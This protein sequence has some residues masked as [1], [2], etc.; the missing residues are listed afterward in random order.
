M[1]TVTKK[2]G[3]LSEV[4]ELHHRRVYYI[5]LLGIALMLSFSFLDYILV[6]SYFYEFLV[7]R[8][9]VCGCALL[10]VAANYYDRQKRWSLAIGFLGYVFAG[11]VIL[12]M[13]HKMGGTQSPYY[14]GLIV[15]MTIYTTLTPLTLTQALVSGFLLIAGYLL[16]VISG[17]LLIT[18]Q[19]LWVFSNFFFMFCFVCIAATQSATETNAR[20]F[21][22]NLRQQEQRAAL[23]LQKQ[24]GN[25]EKEVSQR[26]TQIK[27]SE[28]KYQLLFNSLADDVVLVNPFGMILQANAA[29]IRHFGSEVVTEKHSIFDIMPVEKRVELQHILDAVIT[30]ESSCSAYQVDL[31]LKEKGQCTIEITASLLKREGK[32]VG[33]QLVLRDISVRL[34]LERRLVDSLKT[35]RSTEEAAILALAKLSEYREMRSGNHLERIREFCKVIAQGL[36][37]ESDSM[38]SVTP[39]F[40]DDIYHASVLHDIGKVTISDTLLRK[41]ETLTAL[42]RDIIRN[43]T[44]AGGDVIKDMEAEGHGSGFLA[45]AKSI[46]YFHHERWDGKGYPHGLIGTE[47]PLAARILSVAD[48]YEEMT[49]YHGVGHRRLDHEEVLVEIMNNSGKAFDP[50]VVKVFVNCEQKMDEIRVHFARRQVDQELI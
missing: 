39:A 2:N 35:V 42:E 37:N 47:I 46:A 5:L 30:S 10:L 7:S 44:L 24:A 14:V 12:I 50:V 20:K 11:T 26:T 48:E 28:Q 40:V 4:Q 45:M 38:G 25:L 22:Y 8:L 29:F 18:V 9:I 31:A 27:L 17:E 33:V 36:V 16:A 43:H 34:D 6:P 13:I 32:R 41:T 1:T 19:P 49:R 15:I 23:D 21:E 3:Y